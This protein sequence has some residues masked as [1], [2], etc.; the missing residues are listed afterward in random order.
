MFQDR[1]SVGNT[2]SCVGLPCFQFRL[3][4]RL[5][6][7]EISWS[8]FPT[9]TAQSTKQYEY[10]LQDW[11]LQFDSWQGNIIFSSPRQQA[12]LWGPPEPYA[13]TPEQGGQE[14]NWLASTSRTKAKD[15]GA[16]LPLTHV[17]TTRWSIN[18]IKYEI[19]ISYEICSECT[20]S[21]F[22]EIPDRAL[23]LTRFKQ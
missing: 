7:L 10:K 23:A 17:F 15:S 12:L 6:T 1:N 11:W 3:G 4:G 22:H 5:H 13:G 18:V 19:E 16:I 9:A 2:A 14:W 8:S 20:C 21:S